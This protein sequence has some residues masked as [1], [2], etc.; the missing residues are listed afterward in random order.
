MSIGNRFFN[1]LVNIIITIASMYGLWLLGRVCMFDNIT[2][3]SESM[4]TFL[5]DEDN[6]VILVG[7]LIG[8]EKIG[9]MLQD[10]V[11]KKLGRMFNISK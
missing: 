2:I 1:C 6:N 3:P 9:D 8:N 5:L 7:S 11:K 4:H 10:V